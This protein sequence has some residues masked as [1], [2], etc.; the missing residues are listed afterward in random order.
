MLA[1]VTI[2]A[3]LA[4]AAVVGL[5]GFLT[6]SSLFRQTDELVLALRRTRDFA[7]ESGSPWRMGFQPGGGSW[8]CYC[9]EDDDG[10]QDPEERVQGPYFLRRGVFFGSLAAAGPNRTALPADGVSFA[11]DEVCFSRLGTCSSG[12]LYLTDR[13]VS[14]AVRVMPASGA[15]RVWHYRGGWV[16][17]R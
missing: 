16:E 9:D 1:V 6:R 15:V 17:A 13:R 3:L 7:M 8:S 10:R 11:D 14:T 2:L 5:S 4:S 12:S